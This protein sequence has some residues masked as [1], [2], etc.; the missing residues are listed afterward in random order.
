[1][2]ALFH[3]GQSRIGYIDISPASAVPNLGLLTGASEIIL[4]TAGYVKGQKRSALWKTLTIPHTPNAY[5]HPFLLALKIHFI[6]IVP[7]FGCL[8]VGMYT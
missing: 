5:M 6:S 2:F 1:M 4:Y 3:L 8:C 7:M